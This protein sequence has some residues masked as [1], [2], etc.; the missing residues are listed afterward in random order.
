M[1]HNT[2]IRTPGN[3]TLNSTFDPAE[4]EAVDLAQYESINGDQGGTWAPAAVISIGGSGL[5]VAGEL[6]ATDAIDVTFQGGGA[7]TWDA[8]ATATFDGAGAICLF[9]NDALLSVT[10]DAEFRLNRAGDYMLRAYD[11]GTGQQL[12]LY[13]DWYGHTGSQTTYESGSAVDCEAGCAFGI[14]CA[15]TMGANSTFGYQSG[16]ASTFQ[17][18]A[19]CTFQTGTD[20][21]AQNGARVNFNSGSTFTNGATQTR[22]GAETLSGNTATT[23]YRQATLSIVADDTIY[24]TADTW[25]VPAS[26]ATGGRNYTI[27]TS[28][29]SAGMRLKIR[30]SASAGV[31]VAGSF[32]LISGGTGYT[33]FFCGLGY[34]AFI[35]VE[36]DGTDWQLLDAKSY[37]GGSLAGTGLYGL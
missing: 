23:K 24:V 7:A 27:S 31:N 4:A 37:N 10:D 18:G 6:R 8:G 13:G 2:R 1:A 19:S 36:F 33:M 22:T 26:L 35:E 9:D 34:H 12:R 29:A 14:D 3:W 11:P 5:T 28:G 15:T 25:V 20:L 17:A 21:V 32:Y 16:H 30:H